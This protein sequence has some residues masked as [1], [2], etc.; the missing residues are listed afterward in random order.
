MSLL[1]LQR[2]FRLWLTEESAE[3]ADRVGAAAM[4]GLQIYR[5]NYRAQ[6][7]ACME[8]SFPQ[9]R[10]WLGDDAFRAAAAVHIDRTPPHRWTLDAYP[11]DLPATLA[12]LHPDDPEI[13]ELARLERRQD[14]TA[15]TPGR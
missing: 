1:A 2:D 4:P 11:V 12:D 10:A 6:L 3:A 13:A 8:D 14:T 15:H 9:L 7:M 5:N